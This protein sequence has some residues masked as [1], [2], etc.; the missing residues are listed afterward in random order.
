VMEGD[1]DI[2]EDWEAYE[3]GGDSDTE[4]MMTNTGVNLLNNPGVRGS[5]PRG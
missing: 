3:S 1:K 5:R 4:F 2:G